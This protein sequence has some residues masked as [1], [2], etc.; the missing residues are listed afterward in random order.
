MVHQNMKLPKDK[1]K[2]PKVSPIEWPEELAIDL[3]AFSAIHYSAPYVE[4][5]RKAVHQYIQAELKAS[6]LLRQRFSIERAKI[7]KRPTGPI[8]LIDGNIE[9]Q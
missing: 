5:V 1:P 9:N 2:Y 3:A 8:H 7:A 4:I 6:S